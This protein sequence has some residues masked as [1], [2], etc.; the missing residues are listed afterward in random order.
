MNADKR[1]SDYRSLTILRIST[2]GLAKFNN[3]HRL[4]LRDPQ[5]SALNFNAECVLIYLF[6]KPAS[7]TI[8]DSIGASYD[9]L[10]QRIQSAFIRVYL[11]FHFIPGSGSNREL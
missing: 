5:T 6:Q 2:C 4:L 7:E 3:R 1:G 10:G 11:R 8:R 9:P